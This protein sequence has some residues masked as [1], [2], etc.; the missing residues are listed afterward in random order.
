MADRSVYVRKC[1]GPFVVGILGWTYPEILLPWLRRMAE[2]DDEHVRWNVASAFTQTLGRRF[3]DDAVTI[4]HQLAAD[5]RKLA[6]GAVR[7]AL[8]TVGKTQG[9]A[10]GAAISLLS[11]LDAKPAPRSRKPRSG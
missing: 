1:C 6:R 11:R 5:E 7:A 4:L 2:H 10:G 9:A 8:R 3:P